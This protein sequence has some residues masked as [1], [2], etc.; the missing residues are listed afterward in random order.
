MNDGLWPIIQVHPI[1]L[2]AG[3]VSGHRPQN[4]NLLF[5]PHPSPAVTPSPEGEGFNFRFYREGFI[6]HFFSPVNTSEIL[7]K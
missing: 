4:Y 7:I 3:V 5:S 2:K 6:M 1:F